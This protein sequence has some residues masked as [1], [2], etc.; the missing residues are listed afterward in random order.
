M[1]NVS[2]QI[3]DHKP[4]DTSSSCLSKDLPNLNHPRCWLQFNLLPIER[5]HTSV[6]ANERNRKS[7][8]KCKAQAFQET[9]TARGVWLLGAQSTTRLLLGTRRI[10]TSLF[11]LTLPQ[12]LKGT[13]VCSIIV[14]LFKEGK[15]GP[16]RKSL[17]DL[18]ISQ[19]ASA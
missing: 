10:D 14:R 16:P 9:T 19:P 5:S 8:S 17:P 11:S 18:A 4:L 1:T 13:P 12:T 3:M 15:I 7:L 2:A 6:E